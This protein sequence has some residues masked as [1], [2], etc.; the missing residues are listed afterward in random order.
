MKYLGELPY[1]NNDEEIGRNLRSWASTRRWS[2]SY[3]NSSRNK[4]FRSDELH[5]NYIDE[6]LNNMNNVD[7]Y[8]YIRTY[9][10]ERRLYVNALSN[11][12]M[13]YEHTI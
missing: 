10:S 13:I 12:M 7:L 5:F 2:D 3:S 8:L 9:F 6:I 4:G 11:K 1:P